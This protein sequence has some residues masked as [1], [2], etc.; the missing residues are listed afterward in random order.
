MFLIWKLLIFQCL[1]TDKEMELR[2][3]EWEESMVDSIKLFLD[4]EEDE[5][6]EGSIYYCLLSLFIINIIYY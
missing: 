1:L 2:P 3:E 4:P 5:D 6:E